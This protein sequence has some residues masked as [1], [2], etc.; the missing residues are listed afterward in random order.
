M[1]KIHI[2][3]D[4]EFDRLPQS[5]TKGSDVS[6]SLGFANKETGDAYVR[7]SGS[8]LLNEYLISHELDELEEHES[9]HEDENGIR[10]KK[11]RQAVGNVAQ[12]A[13]PVLGGIFGGP[14]GAG[15]GGAIGGGLK[16]GIGS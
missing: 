15:I 6:D 11:F 4:E 9:T 2:L 8:S 7:F 5:A 16:G 10:H 12:F 13:A 3:S 1:Y 14:V